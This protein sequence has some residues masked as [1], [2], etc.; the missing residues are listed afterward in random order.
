MERKRE[1]K[2]IWAGNVVGRLYRIDSTQE[3]LA[4]RCGW[5]PQYI[6][7]ILSGKKDFKNKESLVRARRKISDNLR[8]LEMEV[9]HGR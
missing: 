1:V 4:C 5:T 2:E 3:E 6:S 8:I 9:L 7:Q